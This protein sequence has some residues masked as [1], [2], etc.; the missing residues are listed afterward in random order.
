MVS[1]ERLGYIRTIVVSLGGKL[2]CV[3]LCNYGFSLMKVWYGFGV[4][5]LFCCL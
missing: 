3:P 1:E 2:S 4:L 5:A